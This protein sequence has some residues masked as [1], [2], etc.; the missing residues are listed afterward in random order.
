MYLVLK[1]SILHIILPSFTVKP[2]SQIDPHLSLWNTSA[3]PS[4][5]PEPPVRRTPMPNKTTRVKV[6]PLIFLLDKKANLFAIYIQHIAYCEQTETYQN[7]EKYLELSSSL[8]SY[9]I[10]LK[11]YKERVPYHMQ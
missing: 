10:F 4:N 6:R 9:T 5:G 11:K 1:P 3:L 2:S 7:K 8:I